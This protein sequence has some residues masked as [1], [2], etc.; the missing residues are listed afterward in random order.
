MEKI[1]KLLSRVKESIVQYLAGREIE[2]RPIKFIKH[3]SDAERVYNFSTPNHTYCVAEGIVVHNCDTI[4]MLGSLTP[5][6]PSKQ[7][8]GLTQ[9]ADG[10]W[11][12]ELEE[13]RNSLD[14][15]IF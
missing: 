10:I 7:S 13:V 6:K 1:L 12:E 9:D 11:E 14:S 3:K 5:W 15:Y 2:Y 8:E 4:S